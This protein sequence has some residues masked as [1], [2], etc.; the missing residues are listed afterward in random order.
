MLGKWL[1][2]IQTNKFIKRVP[3]FH[4]KIKLSDMKTKILLFIVA[5]IATG[6][7]SAQAVFEED[8]NMSHGN[9]NALYVDVIG[10]DKKIAENAIQDLLKEYGKVKK[11]R[12][13]K[14]YYAEEII[15]PSI[16]GSQPLHVFTKVE[17]QGDQTRMYMWVFDGDDFITS[18]NNE[19]AISGAESILQD[20][21]VK[22]RRGAIQKE[23]DYEEDNL[24]DREKE[25][26]KLEKSN[27]KMHKDIAKWEKEI[28]DRHKKIEQAKLDIEQN[29]VDQ[30][31]KNEEIMSQKEVINMTIKKMNDVKKN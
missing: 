26:G 5:L 15:I 23:V 28:E 3:T 16:G 11:N 10:A 13:A 4:S 1:K 29:I 25:M 20:Y 2:T 12:K 6:T 24:K 8:K 7:I 19:E 21:Y 27:E 22:A 14:E 18:E 31:T 30:G 17:E 9:K